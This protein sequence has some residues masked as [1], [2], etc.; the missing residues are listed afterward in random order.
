MSEMNQEQ[1]DSR[2][3]DSILKYVAWL[4]KKNHIDNKS[5][6]KNYYQSITI[7]AKR[8]F[9]KTNFW[10]DLNGLLPEFDQEYLLKTGYNLISPTQTSK[11][12][13]KPFNSVLIKSYRKNVLENEN[14][15]APPTNGWVL[16][17]NWLSSMNDILRT[18]FVV[19]YFDGVEFLAEKIR[20]LCS[21]HN[22]PCEV[23]FEAREEGYYAAHINT[24]CLF[25]IPKPTWDTHKVKISIEIQVTTQV[26]EVIRRLLHKYYE[27]KRVEIKKPTSKWQWDHKSDEFAANYL[28]HILHYVEGTILEIRN[29]QKEVP[30]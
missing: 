6:E 1:N 18:L 19:K 22:M 27:K 23:D 15:P 26:Q 13:V 21:K 14:W 29:K 8:D 30:S 2:K 3:P 20:S 12:L 5:K 9:E 28:G 25:E 4:K 17:N 16:P 24:N 10:I 11:L 7:I